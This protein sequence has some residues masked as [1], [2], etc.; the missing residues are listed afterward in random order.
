MGLWTLKN[1]KIL[2]VDDFAEMRS[3]LRS[4]LRAYGAE[5]IKQASNGEDAVEAIAN[6]KFDIILCDYNLGE[7]KDGQQVLEES[8]LRGILPLATTFIMVTAENTSTMVMG[9]LEYQ[10]DA[11]LSKPVTKLTLQTRLKKILEKKEFTKEISLAIDKK[12]YGKAARL[13]DQ[14]MANH[15]ALRLELLGTRYNLLITTGDYEA[16]ETVCKQVLVDRDVPWAQLGLARVYFAQQ[17]YDEAKALLEEI[18]ADN[19]DFIAA[20]DLLSK[21]QK[22]LGDP[23]TA[24]QTLARAIEKSPKSLMRQRQLGELATI[25]G[26]FGVA[27]RARRDAMLIGKHSVLKQPDD[28]VNY[29][30]ILVKN[31]KGKEALRIAGNIKNAFKGD[32]DARLQAEICTSTVFQELGNDTRAQEAM[33]A[34]LALYQ[35]SGAI[36]SSSAGLALAKNCL[37]YGREEEAD[38]IIKEV[39]RN[40]HE[41]E[42]VLNEINQ[43]YEAAGLGDRAEEKIAE[44]INEVAQI[45]NE[46]V[47]LINEGKI[48]ESI[49]LFKK[50]A[51]AL[52][53]NHVISLNTAHSYILLM[54]KEGASKKHLDEA[55]HYLNAIKDV[56]DASIKRGELMKNCREI[57]QQAGLS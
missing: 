10:P 31:N 54:K 11:Y 50:A 37:K 44:A 39:A 4:M 40:N 14:E 55:M 2:V 6:H 12:E 48:A 47:Q 32:S 24:E 28:Y 7:G 20:Y 36:G 57:A 29:S 5:E 16:A 35:S 23:E 13:C 15:P 51:S 1:K 30:H 46:G 42:A 43:T 56:D 45:N 27:E 21:T 18:I 9:A 34:A 53:H 3:M 41:N 38:A 26:N 25:N 17:K 19:G 33:D 52:P 22:K 8:K 49:G